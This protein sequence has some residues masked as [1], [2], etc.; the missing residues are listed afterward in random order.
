MTSESP[1]WSLADLC[2]LADVTPRT[3]RYYI[4]ENLLPPPVSAGPGATYDRGHLDRLRLIRR[5]QQSR[6]P[7]AEIRTR[8]AGLDDAEVSS[9]VAEPAAPPPD[10]AADYV[11]AVLGGGLDPVV[12][13]PRPARFLA[14]GI[15]RTAPAPMASR[16]AQLPASAHRLVAPTAPMRAAAMPV[17]AAMAAQPPPMPAPAP[18]AEPPAR[19]A[20]SQWDR[21]ILADGVELHVRQPAAP[22][23]QSLV[24]RVIAAARQFLGEDRP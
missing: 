22:A 2:R 3:V 18:I 19:P 15:G 12:A 17:D 21:L 8:L 24:D 5:L 4:A 13:A 10:S 23:N 9:L 14:R 11:R 7:L 20:D 1:T 16:P 6:L